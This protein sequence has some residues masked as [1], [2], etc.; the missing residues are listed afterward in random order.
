[1]GNGSSISTW[2]DN[3]HDDGPLVARYGMMMVYDAVSTPNS[4]LKDYIRNG[5]W[6]F[7]V[8][9]SRD[10]ARVIRNLPDLSNTSNDLFVWT[11]SK[12]S[13]FTTASARN[14]IRARGNVVSWHKVVWFKGYVPRLA[15]ILWMAFK[16]RMLTKIS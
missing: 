7:R 2:Y 11:L 13:L 5:K 4:K 10:L 8:I 16:K 9:V 14:V 12:T 3:W 1:M 6:N 15:I